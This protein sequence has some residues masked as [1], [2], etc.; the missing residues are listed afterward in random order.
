[1]FVRLRRVWAQVFLFVGFGPLCPHLSQQRKTEIPWQLIVVRT[2]DEAQQ[3]IEELQSA[4]RFTG[5]ARQKLMDRTAF[6]S[7]W[8]TDKKPSEFGRPGRW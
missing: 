4:A 5:L 3:V 6:D 8:H 1:M 2:P 7:R